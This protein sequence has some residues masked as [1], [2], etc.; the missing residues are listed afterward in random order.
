MAAASP[1]RPHLLRTRTAHQSGRA[2]MDAILWRM[3]P[4]GDVPAPVAH[5]RLPGALDP[6]AVQT[7]AGRE[8]GHRVLAGNYRTVSLPV[9]ALD[10]GSLRLRV[11]GEQD[12]K[13]PVTGDCH[14]G[15]CGS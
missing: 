4:L 14:A 10:M 8:E 15:I 6:Q 7:A 2:G 1:Y 3:L 13:S 5:Q 9:R 12:D 11:S